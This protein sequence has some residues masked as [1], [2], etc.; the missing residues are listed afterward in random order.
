MV[1]TSF[2][3]GKVNAPV[4]SPGFQVDAYGTKLSFGDAK[5]LENN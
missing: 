5:E 4:A 2:K 1:K 3:I